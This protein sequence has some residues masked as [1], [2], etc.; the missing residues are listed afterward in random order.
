MQK[1][2]V[3]TPDHDLA[4]LIETAVEQAQ[5]LLV[6]AEDD[7]SHISRSQECGPTKT[8]ELK[9]PKP[10]L[11]LLDGM[12]ILRKRIQFSIEISL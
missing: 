6:V 3:S 9:G 1:G 10:F 4:G 5:P 11:F 12:L 7:K 2:D 8:E